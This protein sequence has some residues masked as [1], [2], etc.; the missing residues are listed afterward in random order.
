M[1][2]TI[3]LLEGNSMETAQTKVRESIGPTLKV[4][5]MIWYAGFF[6]V[7]VFLS[8]PSHAQ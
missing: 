7:G 6:C 1:F 3:S 8:D 4:N 2:G 5:W